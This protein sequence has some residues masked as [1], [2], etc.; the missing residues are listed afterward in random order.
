MMN[1]DG[2]PLHSNDHYFMNYVI[3]GVQMV[4]CTLCECKWKVAS[5]NISSKRGHL[6]DAAGAKKYNVSLCKKVPAELSNCNSEYIR[7]L[8]SKS[9][10]KRGLQEAVTE[11]ERHS[12]INGAAKRV[13]ESEGLRQ[14]HRILLLVYLLPA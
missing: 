11:D 14:V 13:K 6:S 10:K 3:D 9:S 5:L 7:C 12:I 1:L 4:K 8:I 2:S